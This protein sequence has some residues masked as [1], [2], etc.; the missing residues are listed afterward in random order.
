MNQNASETGTF[1]L[2]PHSIPVNLSFVQH[3][4]QLV[5]LTWHSLIILYIVYFFPP[6][7][8]SVPGFSKSV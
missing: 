1:V 7:Y 5:F 8:D 3:L 4:L 2:G 6:L